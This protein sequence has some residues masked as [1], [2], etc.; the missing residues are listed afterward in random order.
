MSVEKVVVDYF[1]ILRNGDDYA[2]AL[3]LNEGPIFD[4]DFIYDGRNCAVLTRNKKKA[5]LL[6]NIIPEMRKALS[7]CDEVLIFEEIGKEVANAY[8]VKV[9]HVDEIPYPDN[10]RED[11]EKLVEELKAELG[12]EEFAEL[13][14]NIEREYRKSA[15][16]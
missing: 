10:L 8:K 7:T 1:E 15:K 11:A 16:L 14:R 9:K 2:I 12:E 5:F 13:M 3:Q 4:A 6:T